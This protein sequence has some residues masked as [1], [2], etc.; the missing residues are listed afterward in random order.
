MSTQEDYDKT[1]IE[2]NRLCALAYD[3]YDRKLYDLFDA[4]SKIAL[5]LGDNV[6]ALGNKL[7][8][9]IGRRHNT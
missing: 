2:Y 6:L 9:E 1:Y 5:S 3:A 4:Y 8:K 7:S